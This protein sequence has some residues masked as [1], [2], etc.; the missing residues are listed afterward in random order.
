MF[1][2][3]KTSRDVFQEG[4]IENYWNIDGHKSLSESWI[5]VTRFALPNK[6]P[7]EGYTWVHGRVTKKEVKH[8]KRSTA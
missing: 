7:R 2:D 4:T 6:T 5:G 1:R 3:T 8:V